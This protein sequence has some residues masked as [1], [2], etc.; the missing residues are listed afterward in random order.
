MSEL[1]LEEAYQI[2]DEV[3]QLRVER[4]EQV[5]GF[6]VGCTSSAI[7]TQFGLKEPIS[8]RLFSP[9]LYED[10]VHLD[11]RGY[12][13]CAIEPELVIKI[14]KDLT[15]EDPSDQE[16]IDAIDY[17][18]P[19]IELH[20]FK[21]WSAAPTSQELIASGGIWAGLVIGS[22]RV[23]PEALSFQDELFRVY[24]NERLITQ[25]PASEIMG[26]PLHS[27]RWLVNYLTQRG[28]TLQKGSLIIP[29]SPVELV[30]ITE[31]S[32]LRIEIERVGSAGTLFETMS[33]EG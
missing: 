3:A 26:G 22:Q 20:N 4:G 11:W 1:S 13:N 21:F 17:V 14:G 23:S 8:A 30:S 7:R 27:L 16:L 24:K 25:A 32:N 12:L 31:D 9:Y 19:G 2:Q 10:S 15:D 28:M 5:V 18:S 29:G 33:T 6:K